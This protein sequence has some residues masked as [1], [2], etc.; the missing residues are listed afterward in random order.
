MKAL[1]EIEADGYLPVL[2]STA[3][4]DHQLRRSESTTICDRPQSTG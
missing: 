1:K 3:Q 4:P 2:V